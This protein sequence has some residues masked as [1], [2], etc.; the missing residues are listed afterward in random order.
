[1]CSSEFILVSNQSRV[2]THWTTTSSAT[3]DQ[4][5]GV[6]GLPLLAIYELL[7][8][9]KQYVTRSTVI[10]SKDLQ[11]Q[12]YEYF[13]M[14]GEFLSLIHQLPGVNFYTGTPNQ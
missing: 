8:R 4:A 12:D 5:V 13:C 10:G 7:A 2:E 6:R 3:G 14:L 11:V 9:M 1:M